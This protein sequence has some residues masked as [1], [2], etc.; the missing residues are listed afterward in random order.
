M[1]VSSVSAVIVSVINMLR[2]LHII[3]WVRLLE[4]SVL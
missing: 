2:C 1:L 4:V 3:T